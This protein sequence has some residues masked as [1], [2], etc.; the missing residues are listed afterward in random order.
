M[1]LQ[2]VQDSFD[3]VQILLPTEIVDFIYQFT[4]EGFK[5]HC[6]LHNITCEDCDGEAVVISC[7]ASKPKVWCFNCYVMWW[8]S[9]VS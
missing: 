2:E 1:S 7:A 8:I 6:C 5:Q 9:T 4:P 3:A